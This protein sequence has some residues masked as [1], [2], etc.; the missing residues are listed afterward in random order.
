[1]YEKTLAD[2]QNRWLNEVVSEKRAGSGEG[3]KGMGQAGRVG[4]GWGKRGRV[5]EVF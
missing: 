2:A 1:M 3:R 5:K 4:R